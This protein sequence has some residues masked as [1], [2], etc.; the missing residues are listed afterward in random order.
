[1]ECA[2]DNALILRDLVLQ[3]LVKIIMMCYIKKIKIKIQ[4]SYF[5]IQLRLLGFRS[6]QRGL[7]SSYYGEEISSKSSWAVSRIKREYVFVV[8]KSVTKSLITDGRYYLMTEA[9]II[10]E[11]SECFSC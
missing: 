4:V 9:Q 6:L 1:V 3:E 11:T 10:S 8:P 7:T 2:I 5:F